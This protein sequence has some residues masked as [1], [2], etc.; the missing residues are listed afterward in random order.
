LLRK[1]GFG[2]EPLII[3]AVVGSYVVTLRIGARQSTEPML[4]A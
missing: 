3:V 2:A 4:A 1:A